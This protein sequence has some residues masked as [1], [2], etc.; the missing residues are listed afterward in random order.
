MNI[1]HNRI[2]VKSVRLLTCFV[3]RNFPLSQCGEIVSI[4]CRTYSSSRYILSSNSNSSH[5][6][7][8]QNDSEFQD[9]IKKE[10]S[11][12]GLL[13]RMKAIVFSQSF[14]EDVTALKEKGICV[15][16]WSIVEMGHTGILWA[17]LQHPLLRKYIKNFDIEEF[18][19]GASEA[20]IQIQKGI[21]STEL[22]NY[23]NG[24]IK[25]SD[26][27]ELLRHSL[28]PRLYKACV[29]AAIEFNKRKIMSTMS[30]INLLSSHVQ[31]VRPFVKIEEQIDEQEPNN[32]NN[33]VDDTNRNEKDTNTSLNA[34]PSPFIVDNKEEEE[35]REDVFKGVDENYPSGCVL[36]V[37]DVQFTSIEEYKTAIPDSSDEI[38][39]T[40]RNNT[41]WTFRGCISDHAET[42]WKIVAFDG[43]GDI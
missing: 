25:T 37:V 35:G 11:Y 22:N 43:Y 7:Q 26:T 10:L 21:A 23:A 24:F 16:G 40:K 42:E 1:G 8:P 3:K 33:I 19:L 34:S 17:D 41:I 32:D 38:K 14:E 39:S 29:S 31:L 15:K 12:R 6:N 30:S 2:S 28:H 20:F 18:H 5:H 9:D 4:K 13:P 36:A 27:A